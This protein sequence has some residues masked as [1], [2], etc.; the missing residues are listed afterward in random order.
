MMLD[1]LDRRSIVSPNVFLL[2]CTIEQA[3]WQAGASG[4]ERTWCSLRFRVCGPR[5]SRQLQDSHVLTLTQVVNEH[6][7]S[8]RKLQSVVMYALFFV[9]D[10]PK[11]RFLLGNRV[12]A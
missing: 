12:F 6:D 8:I 3:R 7:L 9:I 5:R 2:P 1:R 4:N 10:L 11:T